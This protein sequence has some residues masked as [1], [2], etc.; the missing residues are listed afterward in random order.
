MK[1]VKELTVGDIQLVIKKPG[2]KELSASQIVYNKAWL[3]ALK[4]G[5]VLREKLNEYM[6]EQ[7]VWTKK[8]DEEYK[9]CIN[10]ILSREK[11]L[12]GGN[13]PLKKARSIALEL[14]SLRAKRQSILEQRTSYD[15]LTAEGIADNA[16]FDY[17]I[18]VCVLDPSNKPIFKDVDDYN[19]RSSEDWAVKAATELAS[20]L[21]DLD[22]NYENNLVENKFL[23]RFNFTDSKGRL[24]NKDGHLIF[25]SEDGTERLIDEDGNFVVYDENNVQ[26]KVDIDGNKIEEI[27][28][29]PFLDDD[30]NPL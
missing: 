19:I 2:R 9:E 29:A 12:K 6:M 7:G 25:I 17:L 26:Y 1:D 22:P 18:S 14:K 3:Q 16:R 23:A 11:I 15:S 21:Y 30:G 27:I 13:I 24:I 28:E 20:I 5:C 10:S 4:D 8:E